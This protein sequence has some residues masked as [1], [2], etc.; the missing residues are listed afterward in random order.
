MKSSRPENWSVWSVLI[1]STGLTFGF[2]AIAVTFLISKT[3]Y[4]EKVGL[5]DPS[6]AS[7]SAGWWIGLIIAVTAAFWF[8]LATWRFYVQV[9]MQVVPYDEALK[10]WNEISAVK[11]FD[12]NSDQAKATLKRLK[13]I[14]GNG[15]IA[16]VVASW[17]DASPNSDAE[18]IIENDAQ[19][20]RGFLNFLHAMA[21]V[22]VLIGLVGNF[23]GLAKA[24]ASLPDMVDD[25]PPAA[26]AVVENQ[27]K[28]QQSTLS[29]G[30]VRD[31][32]SEDTSA[33]P[34]PASHASHM[35]GQVAKVASG[36]SVVVVSSVMGIGS[37]ILLLILVGW[38]RGLFGHLVAQEILLMSVELGAA[39]RPSSTGNEQARALTSLADE[40]RGLRL[41]WEATS[42]KLTAFDEVASKLSAGQI[43]LANLV[44]QMDKVIQQQLT[45]SEQSYQEYKEALVGFGTYLEARTETLHSIMDSTDQTAS[46]IS[47]LA[48]GM[49]K[50]QADFA[51]AMETHQKTQAEYEN[52]AQ[53]VRSSLESRQED[54]KKRHQE[55]VEGVIEE[56]SKRIG[57]VVE[58]FKKQNT[59]SAQT[60]SSVAKDLRESH[61][62]LKQHYQERLDVVAKNQAE[63]VAAFSSELKGLREDQRSVQEVATAKL[64]SAGEALAKSSRDLTAA[65][66]STGGDLVHSQKQLHE[67]IA[68][69]QKAATSAL[70]SAAEQVGNVLS[71]L[72]SSLEQLGSQNSKYATQTLEGLQ[73][74]VNS[75]KDSAGV[76]REQ[77]KE[78]F[79]A[80]HETL[81][82][83]LVDSVPTLTQEIRQFSDSAMQAL[84]SQIEATQGLSAEVQ[85]TL[86]NGSGVLEESRRRLVETQDRWR[87]SQEL[88]I[89]DLFSRWSDQVAKASVGLPEFKESL[90][91]LNRLVIR[92]AESTPAQSRVCPE[93]STI[94]D[95]QSGF[96]RKCN[97]NL[98]QALPL[99][100]F[101]VKLLTSAVSKGDEILRSLTQEGLAKLHEDL[102]LVESRLK[103]LPQELPQPKLDIPAPQAVDFAPVVEMLEQLRTSLYRVNQT[104]TEQTDRLLAALESAQGQ[105]A[106]WSLWR[107]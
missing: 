93:C 75:A 28:N 25:A 48:E 22:L 40:I 1:L 62:Q 102:Q 55:L 63:L 27:T 5:E 83:S 94:N 42:S 71:G 81:V 46:R 92:L 64:N 73:Q 85:A 70:A 43:T 100:V 101:P 18:A 67:Q 31:K 24:A 56:F 77:L 79:Q 8:G 88:A 74:L 20:Y 16:K 53:L 36:L 41:G 58:N 91:K 9:F 23:F 6:I 39:I 76:V 90:E 33:Q 49:K 105:P 2:A 44:P 98:E 37:M 78:S 59:E 104:Q 99:G 68:Q 7:H 57:V 97:Q 21:S 11:D 106:R 95:E 38:Y 3:W 51:K 60:V 52:Y 26:V 47:Q 4:F 96:C 15:R 82:K 19:S 35:K 72:S 30:T 29:Q 65:F 69:E 13:E 45:K 10:A 87:T 54:E 17:D 32:V 12:S 84:K 34:A 80:Q 50:I 61:E 14:Q 89:D 86:A 66:E 107:R 103:H